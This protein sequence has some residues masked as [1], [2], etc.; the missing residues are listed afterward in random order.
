MS[1]LQIGDYVKITSHPDVNWHNWT[2][3]HT[4]IC[5]LIGQIEN[6][7]QIDEDE[8]EY[9]VV[10]EAQNPQNE[11]I[12]LYF[13]QKHLKKLSSFEKMVYLSNEKARKEA[14]EWSET[15]KKAVNDNLK[16]VF[17]PKPSTKDK[18]TVKDSL[19]DSVSVSNIIFGNDS[20]SYDDWL[21][22]YEKVD[23]NDDG[24]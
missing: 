19:L 16:A 17:G 9:S 10:V 7:F 3:E 2:R 14:N 6:I 5:N 21:Y 8:W 12:C 22:E 11:E 4:D 1:P 24:D 23:R 13:L 18:D 20:Y 15:H